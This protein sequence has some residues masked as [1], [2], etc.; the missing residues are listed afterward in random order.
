MWMVLGLFLPRKLGAI[1]AVRA[2][3]AEGMK[4]HGVGRIRQRVR[5]VLYGPEVSPKVMGG[6]QHSFQRLRIATARAKGPRFLHGEAQEPAFQRHVF[7]SVGHGQPQALF[8]KLWEGQIFKARRTVRATQGKGGLEPQFPQQTHLPLRLK[9]VRGIR[10]VG[11]LGHALDFKNT[12][13]R[14]GPCPDKG[15]VQMR[16][17]G[18]IL[19]C[20]PD[21][22]LCE[23]RNVKGDKSFSHAGFKPVP[24][25]QGQQAIQRACL[26]TQFASEGSTGTLRISADVAHADVGSAVAQ[27]LCQLFT[28]ALQALPEDVQQGVFTVSCM[29]GGTP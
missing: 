6:L 20:V 14:L 27:S 12:D 10:L 26:R 15:E 13:S 24:A 21:F 9:L 11:N 5:T 8:A 2:G 17:D 3:G 25:L 4:A 23:V 19:P 16:P 28:L 18:G 29:H 1:R 22:Q 7:E